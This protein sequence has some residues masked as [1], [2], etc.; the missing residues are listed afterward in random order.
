MTSSRIIT[1]LRKLIRRMTSSRI[2]T[3]ERIQKGYFEC[4]IRSRNDAIV[5]FVVFTTAIFVLTHTFV[6]LVK[7]QEKGILDL[8]PI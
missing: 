7:C 1:D 4:T 2:I 8:T 3:D 5:A 6:P